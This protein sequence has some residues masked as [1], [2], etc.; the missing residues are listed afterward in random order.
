MREERRGERGE[1]GEEGMMM[2]DEEEKGGEN[3]E[4]EELK[5]KVAMQKGEGAV[6]PL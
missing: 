3:W 5:G 4:G 2:K 6:I 1:E